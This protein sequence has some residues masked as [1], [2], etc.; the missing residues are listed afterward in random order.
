MPHQPVKPLLG[1]APAPPSGWPAEPLAELV[2]WFPWVPQAK[3]QPKPDDEPAAEP[4]VPP[5]GLGGLE[6]AFFDLLRRD[7]RQ[8][9]KTMVCE[10][11]LTA[12]ARVRATDLLVRNYVSH[13]NPDGYGPNYLARQAGIKLPDNYGRGDKD[14]QIESLAAG[15]LDPVYLLELF[16]NSSA[17]R[18]HLWG[19]N[20]FFAGQTLAGVG[21]ARLDILP[22][23]TG[24][25]HDAW[26]ILTLH[27]GSD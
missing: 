18:T 13:V 26:C 10:E 8:R 16:Y 22:D 11:R 19:L 2:T 21:Y 25:Y 1:P 6:F 24:P 5:C 17:H 27:P 3:P 15:T 23:P 7:P 14:N 12:L 9:R 4:A 20:S